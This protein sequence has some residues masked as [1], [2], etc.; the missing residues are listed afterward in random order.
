MLKES[1]SLYNPPLQ[2]TAPLFLWQ[3]GSIRQK[4]QAPT[5][6]QDVLPTPSPDRVTEMM[7]NKLISLPKEMGF[8]AGP[9]GM[10]C[11]AQAASKRKSLEQARGLF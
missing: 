10:F 6:I 1:F 9:D 11:S 5:E 3:Y 4:D 7:G 2:Y 8:W